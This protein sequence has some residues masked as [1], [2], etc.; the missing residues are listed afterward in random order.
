VQY[1]IDFSTEASESEIRVAMQYNL[2]SDYRRAIFKALSFFVNEKSSSMYILASQFWN[3]IKKLLMQYIRK[4]KLFAAIKNTR[5]YI[6]S[7]DHI[8]Y[9]PDYRTTHKVDI[10][11]VIFLNKMI[12]SI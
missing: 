5:A 10:V 7:R 4:M 8:K 11:S 3:G 6:K 2:L 12:D 9:R 1:A